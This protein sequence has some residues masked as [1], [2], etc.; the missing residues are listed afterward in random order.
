MPGR[1]EA[2][3]GGLLDR[4]DLL[5]ERRERRPAQPPQHVGVAPLALGPARPELASDEPLVL[6]EGCELPSRHLRWDAEPRRCLGRRERPVSPREPGQQRAQRQLAAL[7][8]RIRQAR[9][10]HRT[11]RVL[12]AGMLAAR[13]DPPGGLQLMD[14][15]KSLQPWMVE[16]ILLCGHALTVYPFGDLDVAMQR[17][18]HQIDRVVLPGEIVHEFGNIL[19]T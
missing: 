7:E 15:A 3:V 8:E 13:E 18:R 4:L 14:A 1:Q 2:G 6:L 9:G 17:I 11:Q 5:A 19:M 16:Q 12:E 10:G